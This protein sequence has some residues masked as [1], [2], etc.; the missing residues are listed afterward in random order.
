MHANFPSVVRIESAGRCNFRCTH[1]PVGIHG[2]DR[3]IM[4]VSM[5]KKIFDSLPIVPHT[6]VFYHG[7]EPL[8]NKDLEILIA[9]AKQAGV[10]KTVF[11]TN[12][13]L[14]TM[15]RA[16]ALAIA[17]L[18]EMRVSFDGSTPKQNDSIRRGSNF[19]KHALVV[20]QA[21]QILTVT[22]YN[23]KFDGDTKTAQYLRE[24]FGNEVRYRTDLARAWAHEDKNGKP[25]TGAI[26][27]KELSETFTI[28]SSGD[29]VSCCEDLLGDYV[30][31]NVLRESPLDIWNRMQDLRDKFMERDYPEL[32]K[33]CY[34]VTGEHLENK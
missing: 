23:V 10:K 18:D 17:G 20:K 32:C 22:I 16:R 27:C 13:S 26:Y 11:N 21:A 5:F 14:L 3:P 24:Y 7:G 6:L 30:Y 9:Y 2:N 28:L 31:G 4:P 19:W 33:H 34:I 15:E 1:C 12:A 8:L 25:T 29:V